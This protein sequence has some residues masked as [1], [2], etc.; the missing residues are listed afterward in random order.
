MNYIILDLEW[1]QAIKKMKLYLE[2]EIIQIGAVKLNEFFEKIETFKIGIA[3]KYYKKLHWKVAEL[4]NITEAD[5]AYGFGFPTA[6]KYFKDWCGD[7]FTLLTWANDDIRILKANLNLHK[8]DTDW[9]PASYDLQRIFDKQIAHENRQCSL[10]YAMEFLHK[11]PLAAHDALHDALNTY[12]IT[13]VLDL[14]KAFEEYPT[15]FHKTIS[16]I[17]PQLAG[18]HTSQKSYKKRKTALKNGFAK[19]LICPCCNGS[20]DHI[21]WVKQNHI[22]FISLAKCKCGHEYFIRMKLK[23]SESNRYT[24]PIFIYQLDPQLTAYYI[25][26]RLRKLPKKATAQYNTL[27]L[28]CNTVTNT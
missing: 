26:K 24:A 28:P 8:L 10:L 15:Y 13:K 23:Q 6:I 3:P 2:G 1:N 20:M 14:N 25:E 21:E 4:T 17:Y 22:K 16:A 9:I 18:E 11:K 27:Y 5:L 12:E 7:E 19:E